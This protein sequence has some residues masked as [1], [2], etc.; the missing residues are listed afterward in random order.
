MNGGSDTATATVKAY[1]ET[2]Q[3]REIRCL[4]NPAELTLRKANTWASDKVV[5][6]ATP[7]LYFTGGT[8]GELSMTLLFDTTHDGTPVTQHTNALLDLLRVDPDLPGH[9]NSSNKGRPPWVRFHWGD[10]HSFKAII[11]QLD[12]TFVFFSSDGTPLRARTALTLKQFQD[13]NAWGPQNP[14]S[15]TPQ[16]HRVH[17]VQRGE[18]LDGIATRHYGDPTRWRLLAEANRVIDPFS[19]EPGRVLVI[20][21]LGGAGHARRR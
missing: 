7:D 19:L 18:T 4:F 2:E 12:L 9:D 13:D 6:R 21:R 14:T 20:P 15:G 17:Q 1:L 5:G 8:P 10:L 3:G 11:E 16:P